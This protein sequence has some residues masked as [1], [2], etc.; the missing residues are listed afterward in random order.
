MFISI[1]ADQV[2]KFD[3]SI[4]NHEEFILGILGAI[5]ALLAIAATLFGYFSFKKYITQVNERLDSIDGKL[6]AELDE[7]K[8]QSNESLK[9]VNNELIRTKKYSAHM[10]SNSIIT[11]LNNIRPNSMGTVINALREFLGAIPDTFEEVNNFID[12]LNYF[13][14]ITCYVVKHF[15][16]IK[17]DSDKSTIYE[18]IDSINK[19][20][21]EKR[22]NNMKNINNED[23]ERRK[24]YQYKIR[25]NLIYIKKQLDKNNN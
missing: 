16:E 11:L 18:L 23:D 20:L 3:Q 19:M 5:I 13:W 15:S 4:F 17:K 12:Y 1:S 25:K 7:F 2:Y 24:D 22:V 10:A 9:K 14:V 8:K 6:K 21:S